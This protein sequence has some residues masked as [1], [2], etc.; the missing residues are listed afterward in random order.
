MAAII[1]FIKIMLS[2][3]NRMNNTEVKFTRVDEDTIKLQDNGN[4]E[5]EVNVRIFTQ[6]QIDKIKN[7]RVTVVN[8]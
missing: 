6:E 4:V 2:Q 1:E 7:A 8:S 3:E 5:K